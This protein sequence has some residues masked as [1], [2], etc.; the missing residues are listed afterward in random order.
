MSDHA[1]IEQFV[2]S[3]EKLDEMAFFE[4]T[5]PV[6]AHLAF[7]DPG[8]YGQRRWKPLAVR[9]DTSLL[10]PL[11]SRLPARFPPLYEQ[12]VLSYRWAA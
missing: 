6:A 10:D 4:A 2:A 3:F 12:L 5:D 9:T 8:P 11:Y 7:G 1:L